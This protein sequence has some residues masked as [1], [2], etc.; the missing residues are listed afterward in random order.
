M[1]GLIDSDNNLMQQI[2]LY[3]FKMPEALRPETKINLLSGVVQDAFSK[4]KLSAELYVTDV[5]KDSTVLDTYSKSN[6]AFGFIISASSNDYMVYANKTG[7][8]L[9][10]NKLSNMIKEQGIFVIP[11][12]KLAVGEKVVLNNI[13]FE[14]NSA[15][16]NLEANKELEVA[17]DFLKDNPEVNIEIGGHTD[18]SGEDDY[19]L[20]LSKER[21]KSVLDFFVASGISSDR[22][23]HIGYGES[24]PLTSEKGNEASAINR[25][26]ELL[27]TGI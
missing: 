27:V 7:Y 19:N 10:K 16:L 18:V 24:K 3:R 1:D 2:K 15:V 23:T 25:R 6:G 21:A 4:E 14:L 13:L 20:K 12:E 8:K 26:I 17:L 11:M 22:L 9:Y 5:I